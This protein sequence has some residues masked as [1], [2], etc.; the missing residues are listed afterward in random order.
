[1]VKPVTVVVDGQIEGAV[2]TNGIWAFLLL[3][4]LNRVDFWNDLCNLLWNIPPYH[5]Y[6]LGF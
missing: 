3:M 1:M 2:T 4:W 5:E 6:L